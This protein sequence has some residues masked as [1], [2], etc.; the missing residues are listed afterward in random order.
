MSVLGPTHLPEATWEFL[1]QEHVHLETRQQPNGLY[2]N[3]DVIELSRNSDHT[4]IA[5]GSGK[6]HDNWHERR[7][8]PAGTQQ[9]PVTV[10]AEGS[11]R[12]RYQL[13]DCFPS[14]DRVGSQRVGG[15]WIPTWTV[16]INP[17]QVRRTLEGDYTTA[18]L[19][20][21][22]MNGPSHSFNFPRRMSWTVD[23]QYRC[24]VNQEESA[25]FQQKD[26]GGFRTLGCALV[27]FGSRQLLLHMVPD[28]L[29]PTWSRKLSIEYHAAWGGIPD[30][31][32]R[33]A[34]ARVVSFV[35]GRRLL[36]VGSTS[37][38]AAGI[39]FSATAMNPGSLNPR[40][41]AKQSDREPA[42]IVSIV[43]GL[44]AP[45][46][47]ATG[48]L[49]PRLEQILSVLIPRYLELRQ[50][51]QLDEALERYL[52][53]PELY[54]GI[55]LV[56]MR[57][58]LEILCRSWFESS[59]S[60]SG[61]AY[62]KGKQVTQ[63]IGPELDAI[64]SKLEGRPYKDPVLNRM[65][66]AFEISMAAGFYRFF[67]ELGLKW[68]VVE[69]E[70]IKTGSQGAHTLRM[71]SDTEVLRVHRRRAALHSL[72]DRVVLKLLGYDGCY[73]DRSSPGWP[74]RHIAE[75]LEGP[76]DL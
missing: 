16:A 34:I 43:E 57:S 20:D 1:G 68:G 40:A 36:H 31:D 44:P 52:V 71:E 33:R 48:V 39:P 22:F 29:D 2:G 11:A 63:L 27:T 50:T 41:L 13:L 60:K 38:D 7:S 15:Q 64:G 46:Y 23:R 19:T 75:A 28:E 62:L 56:V 47:D 10:L 66:S 32:E 8:G 58:T 67:D 9:E 53:L 21:W 35:L 69:R 70:A 54:G 6:P 76:L 55:A 51:L 4:I 42:P 14:N 45:E 17:W 5:T 3:L 37:F 25:T 24:D 74:E 73:L 18:W 65:R 59:G 30:E 26:L 61:G 12:V 72:L 49:V